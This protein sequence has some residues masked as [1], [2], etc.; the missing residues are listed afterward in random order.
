MP[1]SRSAC[2]SLGHAGRRRAGLEADQAADQVRV[3][4]RLAP[5]VA[6][7]AYACG[8]AGLQLARTT[9][10]SSVSAMPNRA[11]ST[12]RSRPSGRLWPDGCARPPNHQ[13]DLGLLRRA[14]ASNS[15]SSRDLPTPGVAH[16]GEHPPAPLLGDGVAGAPGAHRARR[17]RPTVLGLDALDAAA[18]VGA[19]ARAAARTTT[20]KAST[21]SS[22]PLSCWASRRSRLNVRRGPAAGCCPRR[23]CR[24][25][26][27]RPGS[28]RPG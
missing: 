25:P 10:G 19:E 17:P 3:P 7:A 9:S 12:S 27:R 15:S 22:K 18:A 14:S 24:R 2:G 16:D 21:G 20:A 26:A 13:T 11:A 6:G 5:L 28:A 23:G 1:G 8:E 4:G